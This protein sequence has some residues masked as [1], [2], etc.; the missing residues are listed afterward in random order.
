MG[1]TVSGF[2]SETTSQPRVQT[3]TD[4]TES[5]VFGYGLAVTWALLPSGFGASILYSG[6]LRV[7]V[8]VGCSFIVSLLTLVMP[9]SCNYAGSKLAFFDVFIFS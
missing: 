7:Y 2:I 9:L 1:M 8:F 6:S 3:M 5:G 4:G